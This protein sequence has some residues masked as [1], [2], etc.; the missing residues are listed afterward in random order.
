MASSTHVSLS[1]RTVLGA[2]GV[3]VGRAAV[4]AAPATDAGAEPGP[5]CL[6]SKHLPGLKPRELARAIKGVGFAGVDLTV[7]AGGHIA[8]ERAATELPPAVE[9]IRGEGL[10]VP[11]ITTDLASGR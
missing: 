8:P 1:R 9:A 4:R 6:F 2:A 3:A 10:Q 5:I 11:H 7:R